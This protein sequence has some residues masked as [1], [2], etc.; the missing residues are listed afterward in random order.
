MTRAVNVV[1]T[2]DVTM[3]VRMTERR[4]AVPPII[5]RVVAA[6]GGGLVGLLLSYLAIPPRSQAA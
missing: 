3:A 5:R 1:D 6:L 4:I 2:T